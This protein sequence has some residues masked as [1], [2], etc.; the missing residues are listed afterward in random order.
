MSI[1]SLVSESWIFA[2]LLIKLISVYFPKWKNYDWQLYGVACL[3]ILTIGSFV[4]HS[5]SKSSRLWVGLLII[6]FGLTIAIYVVMAITSNHRQN[7]SPIFVNSIVNKT[8]IK[9]DWWAFIIAILNVFA[10]PGAESAAYMVEETQQA[11]VVVPRAMFFATFFTY[12][13]MI[14]LQYF[15][16]V[17]F[18]EEKTLSESNFTSLLEAHCPRSATVFILAGLLILT[19]IQQLS[20]FLGSSRFAWALARDRAFP[21]ASFWYQL[22]KGS[23]IPRRAAMLIVTISIVSSILLGLPQNN[24]TLVIVRSDFYLSTIVYFIPLLLYLTSKKGALNLNNQNYWNLK[25]FSK[26]FT[27]LLVAVLLLRFT[28]G[29]FPIDPKGEPPAYPIRALTTLTI[30]VIIIISTIF[31]FLYGKRHYIT[32]PKNI[33]ACIAGQ[34]VE[35]SVARSIE[36]RSNEEGEAFR[37]PHNNIRG[38]VAYEGG[39]KDA[40]IICGGGSYI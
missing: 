9:S 3:N 26:P 28:I 20:Q 35:L 25:S 8:Q 23:Q 5:A 40:P 6:T 36:R 39:S 22:S 33:K 31:W 12:I 18:S 13:N 21:W 19:W 16:Y 17:S 11:E 7:A 32:P 30:P 4:T 24:F 38:S 2:S 14:I 29:A 37:Y 34:E 27:L 1:Y 15:C 10:I